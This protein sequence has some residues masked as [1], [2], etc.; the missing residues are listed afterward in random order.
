[1]PALEKTPAELQAFVM[2]DPLCRELAAIAERH[3]RPM[4]LVGGCVRDWLL[5]RE[6]LDWDVVVPGDPT[7]LA[8]D[9][10]QTR[11][12]AMVTLDADFGVVRTPLKEG[13]SVDFT[14]QQGDALSTDLKRRDLALNALALRL[15]DGVLLDPNNGLEDLELQRI[16]AISRANLDDD[17]L[18]LLRVFRFAATLGWRVEDQTRTWVEEL[19]PRIAEPAGERILAELA[20]LVEGH[21]GYAALAEAY[22]A[23]LLAALI[24][25]LAQ[26]PTGLGRGIGMYRAVECDLME[27]AEGGD[28]TEARTLALF[29]KPLAADR[30]TRVATY[31]SALL[32][33]LAGNE[34]AI[35]AVCERWKLSTKERDWILKS[36]ANA[37]QAAAGKGLEGRERIRAFYRLIRDLG[38]ASH[39]A[40]LLGLEVTAW[41]SQED[42]AGWVRW[43]GDFQQFYWDWHDQ[44]EAEPRLLSGNDLQQKLNLQ[45]GPLFA[46]ILEGVE[47][48]RALGDVRSREEALAWAARM[49]AER[50]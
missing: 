48:A 2:A 33:P 8:R 24:P 7:P 44:H 10:L 20:K 11:K 40:A 31:L 13:I 26:S 47:E 37:A 19:A 14:R 1:M 12:G 15:E 6:P 9:L 46:P 21:Y 25:E 42:P 49:I 23:G 39:G 35:A 18:R 16:R 22:H 29:D 38:P 34:G 41:E 45:P 28:P 30:A 32:A 5:G 3:G 36:I 43:H 50:E 4:A 27:M 17:P